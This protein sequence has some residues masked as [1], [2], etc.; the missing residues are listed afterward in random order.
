MLFILYTQR[1]VSRIPPRPHTHTPNA[2]NLGETLSCPRSFLSCLPPCSLWSEASA[3]EVSRNRLLHA[4]GQECVTPSSS[5]PSSSFL[6]HPP[7]FIF[8]LLLL[9]MHSVHHLPASTIHSKH[10][11]QRPT[12]QSFITYVIRILRLTLLRLYV[13]GII[14]F[15]F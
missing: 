2:V 12:L 4:L 13:L 15:K 1:S 14:V 3:Q 5:P 9:S 8:P 10:M 11:A 6:L 7:P